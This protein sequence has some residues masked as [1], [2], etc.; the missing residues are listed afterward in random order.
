MSVSISPKESSLFKK[1]Q[2]GI[3]VSMSL[4]VQWPDLTADH[5]SLLFS[6]HLRALLVTFRDRARLDTWPCIYLW[7]TTIVAAVA[8]T[9]KPRFNEV[10]GQICSL[11]RGFVLSKTSI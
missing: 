5:V 11:N 6:T 3:N 7:L 8:A 10:A 4:P 2:K 9:V 1:L